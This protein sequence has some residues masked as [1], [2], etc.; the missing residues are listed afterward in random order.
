M[1]LSILGGGGNPESHW[2]CQDCSYTSAAAS[3][4]TV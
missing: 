4:V 1:Y 3:P 2:T